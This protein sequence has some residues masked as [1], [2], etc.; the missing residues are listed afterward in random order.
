MTD[1]GIVEISMHIDDSG[2]VA[3]VGYSILRK[4]TSGWEKI[5][6]VLFN[7]WHKN[8]LTHKEVVETTNILLANGFKLEDTLLTG[9]AIAR[10]Y[11]S[12]GKDV[13]IYKPREKRSKDDIS[14]IERLAIDEI[15]FQITWS[16]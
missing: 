8:K 10:A 5:G 13:P 14:G 4:G 11:Y 1:Y 12:T 15:L 3:G 9:F 6:Y 7:P 2:V 16:Q